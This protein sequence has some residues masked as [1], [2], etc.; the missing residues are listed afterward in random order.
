[1]SLNADRRMVLVHAHPDDEAIATGATMA[2]Y[3]AEGAH[4]TLVTCTRGEE[5]EIVAAD[6]E[7]HAATL[8][9]YREGE[10]AAACAA[11]GV[12]DQRFLGPYRDSGM[13]GVPSNDRADSFWQADLEE[14]TG[15]L[16]RILRAVR[17]QVIVTY[18]EIGTYGHPDHIQAHRV[19]MLAFEASADADRYPD[20][21]AP[22]SPSKL[23][24][25]AISKKMLAEGIERFKA[26]GNSF[27]EG[28]ESVDDLPFGT[29]D[30]LIT[31]EIV[32]AD[33]LDAK[34]AAMRAHRSQI[35]PDA[36]FFAL[37]DEESRTAFG[38]EHY[39]LTKGE[40]GPGAGPDGREQDLFAGL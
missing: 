7:Q 33:H 18:D 1:M 24:Y 12:E 31:T 9:A 32:A 22:W 20:A 21:G 28:V 6:L 29:P 4:V 3:A 17:P 38:T 26:T 5:G 25:T 16:V 39:I 8:G 30:E 34:L 19:T 27:F 14:A 11:L 35:A 37:P 36:P 23:Y 15:R 13:M 40:R 10:L 2:K